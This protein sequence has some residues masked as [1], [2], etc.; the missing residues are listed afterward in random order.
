MTWWI[1]E[2]NDNVK[3]GYSTDKNGNLKYG[4]FEGDNDS[5]SSEFYDIRTGM[6]F[7]HGEN[8]SVEDKKQFGRDVSDAQDNYG[9]DSRRR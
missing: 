2:D 8:L 4:R 3:K 9:R 7:G 5:H 6:T 1:S